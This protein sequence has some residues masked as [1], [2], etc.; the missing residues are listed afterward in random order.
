RSP[1]PPDL[2]LYDNGR[3]VWRHGV[4]ELTPEERERVE[5]ELVQLLAGPYA[6]ERV[7]G[8]A[9]TDED[10]MLGIAASIVAPVLDYIP[11]DPRIPAPALAP[12]DHAPQTS[13]VTAPE[14]RYA[15]SGDIH[16]AYQVVGE[17]PVDLVYIP[18]GMQHVEHI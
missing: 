11:P 17:G 2:Q 10:K 5:D 4:R 14:T 3:V 16:I 8:R 1:L 6:Q 13:G 18:A 12:R 9:A 15:R 7:T